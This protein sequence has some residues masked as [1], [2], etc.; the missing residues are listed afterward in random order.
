MTE[1]RS[2]KRIV[3]ARMEKTGESYTSARASLLAGPA[4]AAPTAEPVMPVAEARVRE[5]TGRGWEEWFDLLDEWGAMDRS[6]A[7]I[8]KHL[9]DDLGIA[10]WYAQSIT[11]AYER[12]RG[13]RA[14]HENA[15]G[16]SITASKTVAV[17]IEAL[18]DAF[19]DESIRSR[20]LADDRLAVRTATRPRNARFDWGDGETRVI[21]GFEAKGEVKSV[22]AMAHE[23]LA[24]AEEAERMKAMWRD[25]VAKLKEVVE[26]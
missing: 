7:E 10:G 2:F 14:L 19:M 15:G 17:P 18:F 9:R 4:E 13:M 22:V 21:V 26:G 25:A 16:F 24:D 5:R 11:V 1:G 20:W 12:A 6:H 3:R 23:R 8:A